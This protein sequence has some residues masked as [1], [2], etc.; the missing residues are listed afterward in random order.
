[1]AVKEYTLE[2]LNKKYAKLQNKY[3]NKN[4]DSI[5]NGG[6]VTNP[7]ICFVFM[8]PTA[9]NIASNKNWKGLK[10]PWIG[11]KNIWDLFE[12]VGL[13]DEDIYKQ[14]KKIKGSEWTIEFSQKVYDNVVKHKYFI[15]NLGKCTQIDARPLKNEV[16]KEYL[17]LLEKEIQ[18]INPE[19]IILFGN[20][21]SSIVLNQKIS[22]SLVRKK[23]FIK[24]IGNREFKCFSV[25]YPVGNGRFNIDKSIEDI[26]WILKNFGDL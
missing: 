19:V 4:L 23:Q 13:L 26:K 22:V 8:N 15:T 3:G 14:I 20:Q 21:V 25:F 6:C 12:R 17:D 5:Y 11:T 16:Y 2:D 10:A 24:K 18:I 1:M 7:K 9:K